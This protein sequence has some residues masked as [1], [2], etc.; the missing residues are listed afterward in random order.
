MYKVIF[1]FY[2]SEESE[3]FGYDD[4]LINKV[5]LRIDI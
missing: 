2:L 1:K 5:V 4:V 3:I